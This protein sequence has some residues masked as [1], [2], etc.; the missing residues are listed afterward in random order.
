MGSE[1]IEYFLNF[2]REDVRW[3][4]AQSQGRRRKYY[5]WI[6]TFRLWSYHDETHMNCDLAGIVLAMLMDLKRNAPLADMIRD[7]YDRSS[8]VVAAH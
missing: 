4:A 3:W 1:H 2:L 7:A 5:L 8:L 6:A